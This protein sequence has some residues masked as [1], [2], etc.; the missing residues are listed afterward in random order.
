MRS[1]QHILASKELALGQ[2][3]IL[4]LDHVESRAADQV[5][6]ERPDKVVI[7]DE[8]AAAF[9]DYDGALLH[10]LEGFLIEH[11]VVI[12]S[13]VH[14]DGDNIRLCKQCIKI[15]KLYIQLLGDL[16]REERV[17]CDDG[18][19]KAL[20]FACDGLADA[21]QTGNT[22]DLTRDALEVHI[23]RDKVIPDMILLDAAVIETYRALDIEH[24]RHGVFG[25]L[26]RAVVKDGAD[27]YSLLLGI[28]EVDLIVAGGLEGNDLAFLQR[29]YLFTAEV[30]VAVDDYICILDLF[31]E[32]AVVIA[33]L[34][35]HGDLELCAFGAA[36][37]LNSDVSVLGVR[38]LGEYDL[39]TYS[40]S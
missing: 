14:V 17:V 37:L 15:D 1:E 24:E 13:K 21:A 10:F 12:L 19:I 30:H 31:V 6:V 4:G 36:G 33:V 25:G 18:H 20:G 8:R 27:A 39:H 11:M 3:R 16:R 2:V 38:N 23:L 29:V 26:L 32:C 9:V 35:E 7:A 40:P 34:I 5:V 22:H 28:F